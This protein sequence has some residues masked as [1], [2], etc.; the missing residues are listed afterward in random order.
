M[1]ELLAKI[2]LLIHLFFIFFVV[3]G[4]F[5]YLIKPKFL[6][7]HLLSLGWGIY[8]QFTSSICPLTYLENWLLIKG[9]ASFYDGGFIE[10][11]VMRIVYPEGINSN[12]Q[13]ILGIILVIL[14]I[15]FYALVFYLKFVKKNS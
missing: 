4:A 6:Y 1:Y 2:V 3:I 13:M 15:F 9:K 5:S 11:Y 14:N 7:L 8:I 12:I 10:N